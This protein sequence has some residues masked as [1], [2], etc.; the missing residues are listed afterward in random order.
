MP[1]AN[2]NEA[3]SAM[4][5]T[6]LIIAGTNK[7]G[8]TSL[9]RYLAD[10]PGV[11]PSQIKELRYFLKGTPRLDTYLANFAHDDQ[12]NIYLEASPQYL[13]AGLAV[14][15]RIKSVLP[16]V[17]LIFLL[18]DPID[19]LRSFF[20]SFRSRDDKLVASLDFAQFANLA[21][22]SVDAENPDSNRQ[23]FRREL[24]RG[25]YSDHISTYMNVFDPGQ[26]HI[27][28]FD[29]L[30]HDA[31]VLVR[32][33]CRIVDL[34]PDYYRNYEF[35][36][37][38]RSRRYRSSAVHKIAHKMNVNFEAYFNRHRNMKIWLRKLYTQFNEATRADTKPVS[39]PLLEDYY[40]SSN[41]ELSQLLEKSYPT[42]A[43]PSWLKAPH[44]IA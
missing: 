17:Q 11:T 35:A 5:K 42:M 23:E 6:H 13:D 9:F 10:H 43:Q 39:S 36:V 28:F 7:A 14:A 21:I 22:A 25:R 8:T 32:N 19:R 44:R 24:L 29:D 1:M 37:E 30:R 40:A 20:E 26:L 18:R 3:T 4:K 33:A 2:E 12:A 15:Q 27:M 38:N 41:R 34:D 16:D 31:G